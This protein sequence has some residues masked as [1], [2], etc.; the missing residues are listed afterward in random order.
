[1]FAAPTFGWCRITIEDFDC[2][3]SYLEDYPY[4]IPTAIIEAYNKLDSVLDPS[5]PLS[6]FIVDTESEGQFTV[7]FYCD[8]IEIKDAPDLDEALHVFSLDRSK[9]KEMAFLAARDLE[10]YMK[11]WTMYWEA[12]DEDEYGHFTE[13]G[14]REI[15]ERERVL[16][17]LLAELMYIAA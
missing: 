5:E 10:W 16:S 14:F 7:E 6:S 17:E 13:K 11:E 15:E 3:G 2:S 8:R 1:M 4:T 9:L 12:I